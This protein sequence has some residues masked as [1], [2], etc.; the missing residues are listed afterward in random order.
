MD[1]VQ[2]SRDGINVGRAKLLVNGQRQHMVF[3]K[4][5]FGEL[6]PGE[7]GVITGPPRDCVHAVAP[8]CSAQFVSVFYEQWQNQRTCPVGQ[9][10]E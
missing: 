10:V 3:Q 1:F 7:G 2:N 6:V 8:Q 5:R 4:G 9:V